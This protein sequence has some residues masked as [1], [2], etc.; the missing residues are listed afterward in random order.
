MLSNQFSLDNRLTGAT[1]REED[2]SG[3]RPV[4]P[5]GDP[6]LSDCVEVVT[7]QGRM[8]QPICRDPEE[9]ANHAL[10]LDQ[11]PAGYYR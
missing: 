8:I 7:P 5:Q 9:Y 3:L 4:D 2:A 6:R 1:P 10:G 11:E